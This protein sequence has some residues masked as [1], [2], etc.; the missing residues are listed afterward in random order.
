M[1]I[2]TEPRRHPLHAI[3][4]QI[5]IRI[6]YAFESAFGLK[7]LFGAITAYPS[8][9][10]PKNA[11]KY[12][13]ITQVGFMWIWVIS[14]CAREIPIIYMIMTYTGILSLM[15][16]IHDWLSQRLI[17]QFKAV[18]FTSA[19][20]EIP[21]PEYD[22]KNGDPETFHKTF[23][24]RPHP[25]I[26]RGFMDNTDLLK[27]LNWDSVLNKYGEE[28]VFLTKKELDGYPGKLKEVNNPAIYLHNSEVLFNKYPAIR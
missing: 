13:T 1:S 25:V 18:G 8:K 17:N 12:D 5:G 10:R 27:K 7:P 11:P 4:L 19:D 15:N 16:C 28:D 3:F 2:G 21:I 20:R 23:V 24:A 22:W 14:A 9:W 6:R 26:L